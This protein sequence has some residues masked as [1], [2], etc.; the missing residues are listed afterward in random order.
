MQAKQVADPMP[1]V[2]LLENFQVVP[3]RRQLLEA[4]NQ[5][6]W[7]PR[8]TVLLERQPD[9]AP[10]AAGSAQPPGSARVVE[11]GLDR[12]VVEA[13]TSRPAI[14]LITD[15]YSKFWRARGVIDGSQRTYDILPANMTLRAVPLA[16]G[17]HRIEMTYRLKSFEIGRWISLAAALL[18]AG[19]WM[20]CLG[21]PGL[22]R[23]STET[24][25]DHGQS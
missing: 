4:M 18:A 7:N 16:A 13:E 14:L 23:A 9:P 8:A 12:L 19:L 6:Q 3:D 17:R 24:E 15:S 22:R 25:R 21:V 11:E 2:S 1:H 10:S 20:R 5:P